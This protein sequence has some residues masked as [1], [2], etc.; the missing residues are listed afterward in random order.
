MT[1]IFTID[2][3]TSQ[4]FSVTS[5]YVNLIFMILKS[6]NTYIAIVTSE[7]CTVLTYIAIRPIFMTLTFITGILTLKSFQLLGTV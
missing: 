5:N 6:I 3:L 2:I 1:L 4:E 7:K